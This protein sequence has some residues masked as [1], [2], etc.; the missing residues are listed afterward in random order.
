MSDPL[1]SHPDRL[2]A[3]HVQEV[4]D[5]AGVIVA[6]HGGLLERPVRQAA[7]LHDIG[8]GTPAFQSYI[9]CTA[10]YRGDR[11][12][13]AHTPLGLTVA[14]RYAQCHGFD[15]AWLL[16]VGL[17]ILGH[18]SSLPTREDVENKLNDD[19][20]VAILLRQLAELPVAALEQALALPADD[21]C[22][23][24]AP[25]KQL[26]WEVSDRYEEAFEVQRELYTRDR[27]AAIARRLQV[28]YVYSVLLEADRAFLALSTGGQNFY[29]GRQIVPWAEDLV[30]R[31]VA[32]QPR[33]PLN[34]LRTQAR[35]DAL[36]TLQSIE[37]PGLLTLTLPTGLGKT[38][39]AA[40]IARA[41]CVRQPRQII[42]V[43]PFL[44]II[45]QTAAVYRDLL[46]LSDNADNS[47]RMMQSHSLSEVSYEETEEDDAA[48][49]LDTWSSD[50][51]LTTIDQLLLALLGAR[52]RHQMRFHHLAGSV[53][54]LDE[55][56]AIP[57]HL[58][59]IC[60]AALEGLV[61]EFGTTVLAMSAT[62][63]GFID[64]VQE[65]YPH[66]GTL[67]R[68]FTRYHLL[69]RHRES[70]SLEAFI[71]AL[72]DRR[73][74]LATSRVLVTLNTRASARSVYDAMCDVWPV[75]VMLL[76]ADL[77]PR[78]RL[79][80]IEH[81]RNGREPVLVVSTQVVEAGVDIDMD[82]V[83]RDFAPLDALIQIA[84]R[85]N[86]HGHAMRGMVEIYS[87]TD[88]SGHP[89]AGMVYRN[90]KGGPDYSLEATRAVLEGYTELPEEEIHAVVE[91]YFALLRAHKNLGASYTRDYATFEKQL[92]VSELLRGEKANR[93]QL[94]VA[95]RDP[96]RNLGE[97]ITA[98][99]A[100][101]PRFARRRALQKLAG[102]IAAVTVSVWVRGDWRPE[103][104]ADPLEPER[105]HGEGVLYPW[106]IVRPD[107]Y[108]PARGIAMDGAFII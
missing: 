47:E 8:K 77:T 103:L 9:R 95:S 66:P 101:S 83:L 108:D 63:P 25:M 49:L 20:W 51:V 100:T 84:G 65:L 23:A 7:T 27:A 40:A 86:R 17:A 80:K 60:R 79:D 52:A 5:T 22:L 32:R 76:S 44:S 50:L 58:W 94:I 38:L 97:A 64:D 53:L 78:D 11:R 102:R 43:M 85:C 12:A 10:A 24:S 89:Y 46:G 42:V 16:Q 30:D 96:E 48:F 56:Q 14:G 34:D 2:L 93:M 105:Y 81:I 54:I 45:D 57:T 41:L 90:H 4:R 21:L 68:R 37:Q 107:C 99:L 75:P 15:D 26:L 71:A 39:T 72:Q 28:Q 19:Q 104:I 88:D 92:D 87:L 67:F 70:M 73:E 35:E 6:R 59:D 74:E 62:Q 106:W 13:K 3:Q 33:T 29:I 18:H 98:A 31:F 91:R 55:V 1:L 69:C 61:Q 36:A 82:I